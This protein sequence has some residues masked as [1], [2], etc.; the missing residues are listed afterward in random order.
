LVGWIHFNDIDC[1]T[2]IT[3]ITEYESEEQL[4]QILEMGMKEGLSKAFEQLADVFER[5]E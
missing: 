5:F 4:Y 3:L 2:E 1:K